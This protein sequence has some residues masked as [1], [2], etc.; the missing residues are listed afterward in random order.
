MAE[1]LQ[2]D[3]TALGAQLQATSATDIRTL[4]SPSR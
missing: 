2:H 1:A 4:G 3:Q